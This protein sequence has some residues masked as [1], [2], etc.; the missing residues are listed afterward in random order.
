MFAENV[1]FTELIICVI[2]E[3]NLWQI[4]FG[5]VIEH[6]ENILSIL[7]FQKR[8]DNEKKIKQLFIK[9]IKMYCCWIHIP[10]SVL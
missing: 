7:I 9:P 10:I 4:G 6:Y 5:F 2:I 3:H 1:L 8:A